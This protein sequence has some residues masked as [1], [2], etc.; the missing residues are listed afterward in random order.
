MPDLF[1]DF[2]SSRF[3]NKDR[4][5]FEVRA[6]VESLRSERCDVERV[7]LFGSFASGVP[8]PRSDV[9]LLIV[10]EAP[11]EAFLPYFLPV[12]LPVDLLVLTPI[13]FRDRSHAGKGVAGE[14]AR[15]G[16]RLL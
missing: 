2:A 6:A 8:T 13:A 14:A 1:T 4:V 10:S 3:L 11:A 15:G 12:P 5:I 7:Y 16:I 9:D